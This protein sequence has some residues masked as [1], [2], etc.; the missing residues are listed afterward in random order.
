MAATNLFTKIINI[1]PFEDGD[2][3]ICRSILAYALMQMKCRL[4]PAILSSFHRRGRRHYIRAVKMFDSKPSMLYPMIVKSLINCW[5]NFEQNARM[6]GQ[7]WRLVICLTQKCFKHTH[8]GSPPAYRSKM[9]LPGPE[10]I[11][12]MSSVMPFTFNAEQ[13]FVLTINEMHWTR[14]RE[15]C[16]ALKYNKKT[17]NILKSHC[18]KKNYAQKY[19]MSSAP[20]AVTHV[21]W[22]KDSQKFD[23]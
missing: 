14:A 18:S 7:C 1:H 12:K 3:K 10:I 22:P 9:T 15:V 21:G 6:L 20:A 17:A 8:Y 13:L 23:I 4:F 16:G 5:D 19:Q 2:G 11:I